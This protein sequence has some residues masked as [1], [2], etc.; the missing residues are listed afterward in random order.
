[1]KSS[2]SYVSDIRDNVGSVRVAL[3]R[4]KVSAQADVYTYN[5]YHPYGSIARSGG[6]TYRYD[7]QGAYSEKDPVPGLNKFQ[8]KMYDSKIGRWLSTDPAGQHASP[9]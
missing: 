5:D 4:T 7:Y 9:Y 2:G 1:M 3:N 6:T 8:L